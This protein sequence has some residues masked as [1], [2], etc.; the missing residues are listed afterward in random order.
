[1]LQ[2]QTYSV[3]K[4][5]T[6]VGQNLHENDFNFKYSTLAKNIKSIEGGDVML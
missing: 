6:L 3:V 5:I 4:I 2:S 1:M